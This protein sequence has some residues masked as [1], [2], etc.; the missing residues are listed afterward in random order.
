VR[1]RLRADTDQYKRELLAAANR[2]KQ[3]E[4]QV[5]Q[6]HNAAKR[7]FVG[8]AAA[9]G[10]GAAGIGTLV[11][12]A[13]KGAATFETTMRQIAVATGAPAASLKG[14]NDLAIDM[15][16]Q[17][18]FSAQ[19]AGNAML[20]LAK[21]GMDEAQIRAGALSSTL[22][23]ASAGTLELGEAAGYVVQGLS[24]FGLS[25][26]KSAAVAAALAGAANAS[27][28][29]VQSIG[30]ALS[31]VGPGARLAG[32]SLQQTTG[33]LAAFDKAGLKGSD[34]GTSLK[35]ML[36]RL[37]PQTDEARATMKRLNLEFVDGKGRFKD[38]GDIAQQ[39]HDRL[40]PLDE[41]TRNVA[42]TTIFG[43]DAFRAAAILM[44]QGRGG[45][46]DYTAAASDLQAAQRLAAAATEGTQ[47][48]IEQMNGAVD[49]A[50]LQLGQAL[51][52]V[53]VDAAGYVGDLADAFG[54]KAV[55]ELK[56]FIRGM[57]D[58]TGP[59]GDFADALDAIGD[60]IGGAWAVA[61]PMFGFVAD[62]PKLFSELAK[63]AVLIAG[64]MK[65]MSVVGKIPGLSGARA[66]GSPLGRAASLTSPVPVFVTNA[67]GL[68][69]GSGGLPVPGGAG[70]G[71]G[72]GRAMMASLGVQ[73][74][75]VADMV[76]AAEAVKAVTKVPGLI[77]AMDDK[78]KVEDLYGEFYKRASAGARGVLDAHRDAVKAAL[79]E[80]AR[81]NYGPIKV[82]LKDIDKALA[83]NMVTEQRKAMPIIVKSLGQ[84]GTD[85]GKQL[86]S[87]LLGVLGGTVA[88]AETA[89]KRLDKVTVHPTIAVRWS[90]T[91]AYVQGRGGKLG[92]DVPGHAL[93]GLLAG[94]GSG[95]SD[96]ILARVSNGEFIVNANATR[97]YL[98][99][100]EQINNAP[101]F[102]A[103]GPVA[104]NP[105]K[106]TLSQQSA[107]LLAGGG[108]GD[109][110]RALSAGYDE[111]LRRLDQAAQREQ[112]LNDIVKA[113]RALA[114][115]KNSEDRQDAREDLTRATSRLRG[116][117][118]DGKQDRQRQAADRAAEKADR[119]DEVKRKAAEAA[120]AALEKEA[121]AREHVAEIQDNM[122][123]LG[124]VSAQ[125]ED[126][127]LT[128]RMGQL[129]QYS[130]AWT[131]LYRQR[132]QVRRDAWK[133]QLDRVTFVPAGSVNAS[134]GM[135]AP[136]GVKVGQITLN[137]AKATPAEIVRALGWI[138][139]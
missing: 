20:E 54:E 46:K 19:E 122:Y 40:G 113:R 138:G 133:D 74:L 75:M 32:L 126:Q 118:R 116:F 102:A 139:R 53:V 34:A 94:P 39:L 60:A 55:P 135:A 125:Q 110:I 1:V 45:V 105:R 42:L 76:L 30:Q 52:P 72:A 77:G 97:Q 132:E 78:G 89:L 63:D 86:S 56:D 130:D 14:L 66:G 106:G 104:F 88:D 83:M 21:G 31:A 49:T 82:V 128:S 50:K 22:T 57:E 16:K 59:G 85:G 84:A 119:R 91:T 3:L 69:I 27:T 121:A 13:V 127:I 111:Y 38:V 10:I 8:L 35:T 68:P 48:A 2:T 29:S 100:L 137:D 7:S 61:K 99:F 79:A 81:G 64:A 108:S 71:A 120:A 26:D 65:A 96:D 6:M 124:L 107:Q 24:T 93:G 112:M 33:V 18:V 9:T 23:L 129:E 70:A 43:S 17:T 101:R 80:G 25:A 11:A 109:D 87:N 73:T 67:G 117:D 123:S 15:G 4:R 51:A 36:A 103:G 115:A 37:V 12:S 28:A 62:H 114:R 92:L 136:G 134:T 44:E 41:A 131:S 95:T 47:G 98:P 58:G 90:G 5:G